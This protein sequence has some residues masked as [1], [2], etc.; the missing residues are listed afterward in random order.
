MQAIGATLAHY[1]PMLVHHPGAWHG[2]EVDAV[3]PAGSGV[4][5]GPW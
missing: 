1:Q 5:A 3:P 2:D 4:E